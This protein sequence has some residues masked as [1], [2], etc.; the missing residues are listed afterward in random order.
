LKISRVFFCGLRYQLLRRRGRKKIPVF[1]LRGKKKRT[2]LLKRRRKKE[3]AIPSEE[4]PNQKIQ[5]QKK[6]G[7]WRET[8]T[9][10]KVKIIAP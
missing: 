4:K 2:P 6:K 7:T 3:Q 1:D 5:N 8:R 9:N 10:Q